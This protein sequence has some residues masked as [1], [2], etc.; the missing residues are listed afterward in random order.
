[1]MDKI[2]AEIA[3][4]LKRVQELVDIARA[5]RSLKE[6]EIDSIMDGKSKESN[7]WGWQGFWLFNSRKRVSDCFRKRMAV[8][9][10]MV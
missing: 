1:M 8:G 9:R 6:K 10:C 3:A 2:E 4:A 5:E 7:C